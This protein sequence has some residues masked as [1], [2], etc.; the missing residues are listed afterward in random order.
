MAVRSR[1][2]LRML[3]VLTVL[4]VAP[5]LASALTLY[6]RFALPSAQDTWQHESLALQPDLWLIAPT[7]ADLGSPSGAPASVTQI[8]SVLGSL[9][10]LE[11]GGVCASGTSGGTLYPC[12]IRVS[13]P[14]LAG[15][16][17]DDLTIPPFT[18]GWRA[19]ENRAVR[20]ADWG[21]SG[22]NP[23]GYLGVTPFSAGNELV[24]LLAPSAF[25]GNQSAAYGGQLS[26]YIMDLSNPY[27][28]A[29]SPLV[30]SYG[31]AILS[32]DVL[33]E[34]AVAALTAGALFA[35]AVMRRRARV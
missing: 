16:V 15:L 20:G 13:N 12:S 14:D 29:T 26:F 25:L 19:T 23:G 32:T 4:G 22:G 34:P 11:I 17:S 24:T 8:Q 27:A 30:Y 28:P 6:Q 3:T 31:I 2:A 1:F 10:S 35:L 33:P 9:G 7:A 18:S 5:A 21:N